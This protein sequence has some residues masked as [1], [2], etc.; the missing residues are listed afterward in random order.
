MSYRWIAF[1]NWTYTT[2]LNVSTQLRSESRF[3]LFLRHILSPPPDSAVCFFCINRSKQKVL[4][5]FD[6]VDTVASI[7]L[8]GVSIGKTDNMFR[9]YV[10]SRCTV[11]I[12]FYIR[13]LFVWNI[14][15]F[16]CFR[17]S[18]SE[19]CWRMGITCWKWASRLRF[20]MRL[21]AENLILPT[22][23]LL[24]VLQMSRRGNVT[25]TLSEKWVC[26]C[27]LPLKLKQS[28]SKPVVLMRK[29]L[30]GTKSF[31]FSQ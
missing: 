5:V 22:E 10:R 23:F 21:S 31:K 25:S 16:W 11:H 24:N 4:L 28:E 15:Y 17:T 12:F 3:V 19:T 29:K 30:W 20:F 18:R 6:G 9:R 14:V 27:E 26:E 1:D 13:A 7:Q 8:N 2:T